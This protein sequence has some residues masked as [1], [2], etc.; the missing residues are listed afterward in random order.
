MLDRNGVDKYGPPGFH[1]AQKEKD[2]VQHWVLT[3]LS[4]AGFGGIFKGGTCLQKAF[5]LPRYSEDLDFTLNEAEG[6]PDFE[7][8]SAFLSSAGFSGLAWKKVE[9]IAASSSAKLRFRGPLYN[10]VSVSEGAILL[11]FSKREKTVLEPEAIVINPPY[12]DLLP[13]QVRVMRKE[14]IA[15]EKIRA[16]LTRTSARDLF[17][18][19]FLLHQKTRLDLKLTDAKLKYYDLTFDFGHFSKKVEGLRGEWRK[20]MTVLVPGDAVGA[21]YEK[22]AKHVLDEAKKQ[23]A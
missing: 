21:D 10:G 16:V 9:T 18:L 20:E 15:A 17:D 23:L 6:E 5:G 2:Y 13:Y 8:I 19:Y 14:E 11:E 3:Y 12:P 4:R 22:I 1:L 7:A